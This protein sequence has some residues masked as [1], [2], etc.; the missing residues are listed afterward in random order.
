MFLRESFSFKSTTI[1]SKLRELNHILNNNSNKK[2]KSIKF[3]YMIRD[4]IF[5]K[6]ERTKF[7]DFIVPIVPVLGPLP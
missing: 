1:F 6:Y 5:S 7:F 4:D 2:N 3:I